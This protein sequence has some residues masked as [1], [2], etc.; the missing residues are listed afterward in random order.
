MANRILAPSGIEIPLSA[1]FHVR[2]TRLSFKRFGLNLPWMPKA[3]HWPERLLRC[4]SG[5]TIVR[6]QRSTSGQDDYSS[7]VLS[8]MREPIFTSG[9]PDPVSEMASLVQAAGLERSVSKKQLSDLALMQERLQN[10]ITVLANLHDK[11]EI[12]SKEYIQQLDGALVEASRVGE[13]IL[14]FHDFHQ[15]F[16]DLK[17]DQLI[18]LE[19]FFREN[20]N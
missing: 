16:G 11:H 5:G 6:P 13:G 8:S 2:A 9:E 1:H 18:D 12:S 15:V 19:V 17:A 7:G 20:K 14:G 10:R 3:N 4:Q